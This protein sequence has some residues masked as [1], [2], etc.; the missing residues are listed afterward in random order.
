MDQHNQEGSF[1]LPLFVLFFF[2]GL[3]GLIHQILWIRSLHLILGATVL[4]VSVVTASYMAGLTLGSWFWGRYGERNKSPLKVYGWME[5]AIGL[6][7][8]T[9]PL[10][11]GGIGWAR[12]SL[13][14]TLGLGFLGVA[15]LY[16]LLAMA[17]LLFPTFLMGGTL[18]ILAPLASRE[19]S[20]SAL[21]TVNTLG[22]AL[23]VLL[24]GFLLLPL[25]GLTLSI[26]V[27]AL[28]N[29]ITGIFALSLKKRLPEFQ[30][31]EKS[32]E[33]KE[34]PS[35][36]PSPALG[37]LG[38]VF[39]T[40][41]ASLLLEVAWARVIAML[42]GSSIYASTLML[43]LFLIGLGL[44]AWVGTAFF[45][46]PSRRARAVTVFLFL[47]M[48]GSA[49]TILFYSYLPYLFLLWYESFR[50]DPGLLLPVKFMIAG[51]VILPV[52]LSLGVVFPLILKE[53]LNQRGHFSSSTGR[54]YAFNTLGAILGA[55]LSGFFFISL[56]G[57]KTAI[58]V[59]SLLLG[60]ACLLSLFVFGLSLRWRRIALPLTVGFMGYLLLFPPQW[61]K[62]LMVS[63]TSYYAPTTKNLRTLDYRTFREGF[64]KN[65]DLLYY[66]E[67]LYSTV[68]V[69]K[70]KLHNTIFIK[71]D[72]KVE[73]GIPTAKGR[74]RADM[75]T[76]MLLSH[77][78]L[79][80]RKDAREAL[81]I[82]LGS[83]VTAGAVLVHPQVHLDCV[84]IEGAIVEALKKVPEF[85]PY[86]RGLFKNQK[87]VSLYIDDARG[88]LNRP[89]KAYDVII[90][91]P[92]DPWITGSS[93]LFTEEFFQMAAKRLGE[94]GLFCQWIQLY[95]LSPELFSSL[96]K[97]FSKVFPHTFIFKP[98]PAQ[99]VLLLGSKSS[100]ALDYSQLKEAFAQREI[101]EDLER[102]GI[103]HPL[104]LYLLFLMGPEEIP[105][106]V[107]K[108]P[109]NTDDNGWIETR[110]PLF[111]YSGKEGAE[112]V[113]K[114]I[115]RGSDLSRYLIL[116]PKEK[117]Q[118]LV[119][120]S[121]Y[122]AL[123]RR[124]PLALPLAERAFMESK[125]P[126]LQ[127]LIG[128]ICFLMGKEEEATKW[129]DRVLKIYPRDYSTLFGMGCYYSYQGQMDRAREI[130][131]RVVKLYSLSN[132]AR[133]FLNLQKAEN[134]SQGDRY[135]ALQ[136]TVWEVMLAKLKKYLETSPS[137]KAAKKKGPRP[138]SLLIREGGHYIKEG[139]LTE[140]FLL[141][142]ELE[143]RAPKRF[144]TTFLKGFYL[145]KKG[146]YQQGLPLMTRGAQNPKAPMEY[147]LILART[148]QQAGYPL[149]A[150]KAYWKYAQSK[151]YSASELDPERAEYFRLLG[152]YEKAVEA[153]TTLIRHFERV[154]KDPLLLYFRLTEI[155]TEE[156]K[157]CYS[158]LGENKNLRQR[159]PTF[160][161]E[162]PLVL[163][164][165]GLKE[166]LERRFE[167]VIMI[168]AG[169]L[170]KK[171]KNQR[172]TALREVQSL[173]GRALETLERGIY[174]D[175][176]K[177]NYT[178]TLLQRGRTEE[179]RP[180]L[181]EIV[182]DNP[183]NGWAL[184][185][186]ARILESEGQ[187][188][189]AWKLY[190]RV[191]E[192]KVPFRYKEEAAKALVRL[193]E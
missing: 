18:P 53:Y 21:Y 126:R 79:I 39:L 135:R 139:N 147:L 190:K 175:K 49:L 146:K 179:A 137:P 98:Y 69:E 88:F 111:R 1:P 123:I 12:Y 42:L 100:F 4:S 171:H 80:F 153:L 186:L 138:L 124:F 115:S 125:N 113:R 10:L 64:E 169:E 82:G 108:A 68:S 46:G 174:R 85:T 118:I 120:L 127:K 122:L 52:S 55:F 29:I 119:Q 67:G 86:L 148:C 184:F 143:L 141:V 9:L 114:M 23:G 187:K 132:E 191:I 103:K 121:T 8:L 172:Y 48:M 193:G 27:A 78:P 2:S 41:F 182:K 7:G 51:L 33:E 57:V 43:A 90:S 89:G 13:L 74:T 20:V 36:K 72:G 22:G 92:S 44:G 166:H 128:D 105:A 106:L 87:R 104:G 110:A 152:D 6:Y 47:S 112:I 188:K 154:E 167:K 32:K 178:S 192:S 168:Y 96:V 170:L 76:Q 35:K 70:H 150:R 38:L 71:N 161:M 131:A 159:P 94:K 65:V 93:G 156:L 45:E 63:G 3:A 129:W 142:K 26:V 14:G 130:F 58:L 60:L 176:I 28:T 181:K 77:L 31:P 5:I 91:Q 140:A 134:Y 183:K 101:R 30:L 116:P 109:L 40:G 173:L 145:V 144:E 117:T 136:K 163:A 157:I 160:L 17:I 97:T 66:R 11:F 99:E 59:A 25:L 83:G 61:E 165:E 24:S 180:Y 37:F 107:E 73:G 102:A 185:Q 50:T 84:E 19:K 75:S 34:E 164:L 151:I 15:F 16:S 189:E 54:L 158:Y 56:W 177:L 162:G 149:Q 81:V 62:K 133:Y 95:H 155:C